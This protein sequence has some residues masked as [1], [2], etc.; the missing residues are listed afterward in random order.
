VCVRVRVH[1]VYACT[2]VD[3]YACVRKGHS[4]IRSDSLLHDSD[5]LQ[6][7]DMVA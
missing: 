2:D 6:T 4:E 7:V 3:D 5:G 1:C